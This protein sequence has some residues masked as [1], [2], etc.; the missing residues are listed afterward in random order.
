M[1]LYC[2]PDYQINWT[3]GSGEEVQN[4]FPRQRLFFYLKVTQMLP[5]KF[6]VSWPFGSGEEA[7]NKF[8]IWQPWWP[9]W[10]PIRMILAVLS[11]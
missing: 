4:R 5:T 1:A 10:I 9:S 2:S 6:R 7:K 3:F 8:L 11:Y